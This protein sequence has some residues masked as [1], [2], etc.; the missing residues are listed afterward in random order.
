MDQCLFC[1]ISSQKIP[2]Q[3][4]YEDEQIVAFQDINPKSPVHILIVPKK[5]IQSINELSLD[6]TE[7]LGK[8]FLVAKKLAFDNLISE[9]G[10]RLVI[11]TRSHAGQTVDHIHLHLLGGKKLGSM[12]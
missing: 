5:H 6:D 9:S 12:G 11:N 7:L 2:C 8:M 3:L 1:K 4:L 10:F